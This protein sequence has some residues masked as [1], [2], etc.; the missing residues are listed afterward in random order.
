MCH[1]ERDSLC[2]MTTMIE[3]SMTKSDLIADLCQYDMSGIKIGTNR[4]HLGV[5]SNNSNLEEY[6]GMRRRSSV[7]GVTKHQG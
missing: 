4:V 7:I 5:G 3:D 6:R 2:F 1:L